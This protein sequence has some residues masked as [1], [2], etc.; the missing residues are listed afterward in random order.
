MQRHH[1][2]DERAPPAA[3]IGLLF[4][5]QATDFRQYWDVRFKDNLSHRRVGGAEIN[6]DGPDWL[7]KNV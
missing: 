4:N 1:G 2:G 6:T 5:G 3:A 7:V